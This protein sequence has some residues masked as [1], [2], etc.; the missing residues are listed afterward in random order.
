[1]K[2][3]DR[4]KFEA[5]I[6][7]LSSD[8]PENLAGEFVDL[9]IEL[10]S[11]GLPRIYSV[12]FG[13]RKLKT[14]LGE[15]KP[16]VLHSQGLRADY[17]CATLDTCPVRIATQR[18]N[19][20]EDYPALY[21][22]LVG[23]LAARFHYH[24]LSKL[25]TVVACSQTIA[26]TN[27]TRGYTSTIIRNGVDLSRSE[28][29]AT[30]QEKS[31][32]RRTLNLP[33][34]GRLFIYI[35]PLIRRKN[36]EFLL[37][38]FLGRNNSSDILCLLGSGPLLSICQALAN[39]TEKVIAPGF[40]PN[41]I[42]Y[43]HAA[44]VFVSSSHAE[45]MPNAVLEALNMGLPVILSDIP[46]HR[47]ILNAYPQAGQLYTP[48]NAEELAGHFDATMCD[49]TSRY[50]ARQLVA[51]H[52]SAESMSDAYQQLYMTRLRQLSP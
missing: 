50:A 9:G 37:R 13:S 34:T 23:S 47:E 51:Q 25:P 8:P 32:K 18:N 5:Q 52:F 45:G 4:D 40:V 24:T 20:S 41:V 28:K 6:V 10:I 14:I 48:E 35:G 42:D 2:Y 19:P 12:T 21:G 49:S 43:L 38:T 27:R 36:P 7:T 16:D 15:L 46:A 11:L 22:T 1:V 44:D 17:L 3:L 33:I 26:M 29:L 30:E 31:E 39:N